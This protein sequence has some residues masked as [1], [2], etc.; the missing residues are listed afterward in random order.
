MI[1][2]GFIKQN[3]PS[4]QETEHTYNIITC[5]PEPQANGEI[6]FFFNSIQFDSDLV[7]S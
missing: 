1:Y 3:D 6:W 4:V 5:N 2:W 7:L